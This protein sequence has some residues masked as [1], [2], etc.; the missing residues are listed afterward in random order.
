MRKDLFISF[1]CVVIVLSI[2]VVVIP[3][4][5]YFGDLPSFKVQ[6]GDRPEWKNVLYNDTGWASATVV[7]FKGNWWLR[8]P[9]YF[10]Q[11]KNH[12]TAIR[13]EMQGAYELYVDGQLAGENGKV[14]TDRSSEMPGKRIS[15]FS[16]PASTAQITSHI[17]ALR[18]SNYYDK[19]GQSRPYI[20][21][22]DLSEL[23]H[24]GFFISSVMYLLG[25]IFLVTGIYFLFLYFISYPTLDFFLFG[26]L[27]ILLSVI[28]CLEYIKVY[29]NYPY[30][31]QYYRLQLINAFS[32]LVMMKLFYFL[33]CRFNFKNAPVFLIILANLLLSIYI[34]NDSFD[35]TLRLISITGLTASLLVSFYAIYKLKK[36]AHECFFGILAC[37]SCFFNYDVTVYLGFSILISCMLLS[38]ARKIKESEREKRSAILESQRL[39]TE[40][41]K[42]S[43]QPHYLI[44]A[45]TSLVE[46]V[47]TTPTIA[48]EFINALAKEFELLYEVAGKKLISVKT[49]IALVENYLKIMSYRSEKDYKLKIANVNLL[50]K[51]PPAI[52][53][54][55]IENGIRHNFSS[56]THPTFIIEF[57]RT[58]SAKI[59]TIFSPGEQRQ[60]KTGTGMGFKY[61][62]ARL[63]ETYYDKFEIT[64]VCHPQSGWVT[65]IIINSD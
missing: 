1:I 37:L 35:I 46:L 48:V 17:L 2:G 3:R 28:V 40:L 15:F 64:S 23:V 9:L 59:Y 36:G 39:E 53:L 51:I 34:L 33:F 6:Q 12:N 41:L 10:S 18:I 5:D 22:G 49:E 14:G 4:A 20:K 56:D 44:N 55:I 47:E 52:F 65:T 57:R 11:V 58:I 38:I 19:I 7:S 27:C 31:F 45:L 13:I 32:F 60:H 61:I 21:A 26:S 63:K 42:R 54:T 29:F 25:G 16:L 50:E 24:E 62:I 30:P 8:V 43:I